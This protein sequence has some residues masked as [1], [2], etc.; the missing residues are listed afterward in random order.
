MTVGE[1]IRAARKQ[2]G[3]TQKELGEIIGVSQSAIGQFERGSNI[4]FETCRKVASALNIPLSSLIDIT[5]AIH[6]TA[7][8]R[9]KRLEME[10]K[11][12]TQEL[13]DAY[14][15]LETEG[16]I[17][18]INYAKDLYPNYCKRNYSENNEKPYENID[19]DSPDVIP[20]DDSIFKEFLDNLK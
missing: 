15:Q 9:N 5:D 12:R 20:V 6:L 8:K 14:N 1:K 13:L 2:A 10:E 4:Q 11:A 17:K 3:L 7:K 16:Q 19:P 18:V